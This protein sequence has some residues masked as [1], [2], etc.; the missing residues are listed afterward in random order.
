MDG[1]GWDEMNYERVIIDVLSEAEIE[2]WTRGKNVS[3]ETVN[4]NCPL[5]AIDGPLGPDPSNHCGIFK[6]TLKFSC[7]RCGRKGTLAFLL[8]IITH[9]KIAYCEQLI[10]DMG[11]TLEDDPVAQVQRMIRGDVE[12]TVEERNEF[13]GLPRQFELVEFDTDFPLIDDY[14]E[15]RDLYIEDLVERGCGICRTGNCMNR[16]VIPVVQDGEVVAYQAADMTGN[17]QIKYKTSDTDMDYLYGL[18]DIQKGGMMILTEGILDAWRVKERAVCVFG[19]SLT[20]G[21]QTRI[22]DSGIQQLVFAWDGDAYWKARE[23]ADY[24]RP[25]IPEVYVIE[26]PM[27]EDPDSLGHDEA[28]KLIREETA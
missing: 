21:Q 17:A 19:A 24:F 22:I 13:Q 27:G 5:C 26:L 10:M 20:D 23:S 12:A 18:D 16:L 14:L 11:V 8:A 25:F 28:W 15:W 6:E 1:A 9:T 4:I 2:F 3:A 7:W